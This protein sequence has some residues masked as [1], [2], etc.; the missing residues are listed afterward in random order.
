M[1][2]NTSD[3]PLF[4]LFHSNYNATPAA[5]DLL[6]AIFVRD[7][8]TRVT[9]DQIALH[10]WTLG[11]DNFADVPEVLGADVVLAPP[12]AGGPSDT[13]DGTFL[14]LVE[15]CERLG[16]VCWWQTACRN[17]GR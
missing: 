6:R 14:V 9:L 4:P 7:P 13:N 15:C 11:Y 3:G 5:S 10:A 2:C 17:V 16:T 1:A 8:T 12:G